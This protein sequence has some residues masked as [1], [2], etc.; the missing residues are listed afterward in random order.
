M[1]CG[2]GILFFVMSFVLDL[3]ELYEWFWE[4]GSYNQIIE[5]KLHIKE[6]KGLRFTLIY[7][8]SW[9]LECLLCCSVSFSDV[10]S[11]A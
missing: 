8:Y 6:S 2:V 5:I 10:I 7:S 1:S 3:L 4:V 9:N 11:F